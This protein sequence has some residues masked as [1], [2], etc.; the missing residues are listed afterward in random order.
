MDDDLATCFLVSEALKQAGFRVEQAE[1]GCQ[2]L[3]IFDQIR[4]DLI[5][6]DVMMPE[7]DGFATCI[8]LRRRPEGTQVP[9][10]MMTG[11]DDYESVNQAFMVGATDFITKPINF[12]LLEYPGPV[13]AAGQRSDG[14]LT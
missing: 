9:I 14:Q 2:A 11:L 6:L 4:P 10:L 1:N 5:T 8:E 7:L 3:E 12:T 13:S